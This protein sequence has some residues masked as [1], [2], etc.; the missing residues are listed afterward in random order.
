VRKSSQY[1]VAAQRAETTGQEDQ[2]CRASS[3]SERGVSTHTPPP[4][5]PPTHHP[6]PPN[7][8][9]QADRVADTLMR[10]KSLHCQRGCQQCTIN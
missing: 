4:T 6:P 3:S 5:H 1:W 8:H 2:G 9:R 10:V 7:T